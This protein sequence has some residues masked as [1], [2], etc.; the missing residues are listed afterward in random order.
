MADD[1]VDGPLSPWWGAW[2]LDFEGAPQHWRIGPLRLWLGGRATVWSVAHASTGDPFDNALV[3]ARP[4][5]A[6]PDTPAQRL[7][8]KR[9]GAQVVLGARCPDRPI[10]VRPEVPFRLLAGDR[11]TLFV[12][13]A[14]WVTVAP[15][16]GDPV[17]ELPVFR[18]TDTWIGP[19]TR[20]GLLGYAGRTWASTQLA[21][22]PA[23]PGRAVTRLTLVNSTR[24]PLD[25]ERVVLPMPSLGVWAAP[26]QR[27]WTDDVTYELSAD[28]EGTV[29]TSPPDG[30]EPL[31]PP[32]VHRDGNAFRRAWATLFR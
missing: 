32:R 1:A 28:P 4:E 31:S 3:V 13:T 24:R 18:P 23:R 20:S 14:M 25:F 5:A 19:N 16:D 29:R 22:L 27:L 30:A 9:L 2:P 21:H 15:D 17:L 26:D 11:V 10:A 6:P 7:A 12:G 8:S